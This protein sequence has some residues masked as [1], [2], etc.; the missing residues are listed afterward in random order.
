MAYHNL[1]LQVVLV[2]E[3]VL[4]H[5]VHAIVHLNEQKPLCSERSHRMCLRHGPTESLKGLPKENTS[6]KACAS[7]RKHPGSLQTLFA[8]VLHSVLV[9]ST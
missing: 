4:H 7:E 9:S 8:R 1:C 6:T 3:V 5:R 2:T